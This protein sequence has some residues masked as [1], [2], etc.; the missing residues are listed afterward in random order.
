[1]N[2]R[3]FIML[4]V[5]TST[6]MYCME[7]SETAYL[8]KPESIVDNS[9]DTYETYQAELYNHNYLLVAQKKLST[10]TIKYYEVRSMAL[11]QISNKKNDP[12]LFNQLKIAYDNLHNEK[13]TTTKT[14]KSVLKMIPTYLKK[15]RKHR[16]ST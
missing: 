15:I 12:E 5:I 9:N 13:P 16:K 11:A 14:K 2:I 7:E 4:I 3:L 1:M 10:G 6:S 8:F